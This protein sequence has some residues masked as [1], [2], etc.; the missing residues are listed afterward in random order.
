MLR[1]DDVLDEESLTVVEGARVDGASRDDWVRG[2]EG[3][4]AQG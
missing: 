3:F 1:F 2:H 4:G